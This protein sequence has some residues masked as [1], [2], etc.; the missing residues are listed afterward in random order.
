MNTE[1]TAERLKEVL[2]YEPDTGVFTWLHKTGSKSSGSVAGTPHKNG[3]CIRIMIDRKCYRAHR[4]AWLYMTGEWPSLEIDHKNTDGQDNRW[5]NLRHSDRYL[6]MQNQRTAHSNNK[7]GLLGVSKQGRKYRARITHNDNNTSL[8]M[9][10]SPEDA[11]KAYVDAK[12]NF[13]S[14]CTL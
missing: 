11:H 12:R 7:N 10:N 9:H 6:N 3:Y 14:G 5:V 4:L 8:G 2:N 1:L 13:H